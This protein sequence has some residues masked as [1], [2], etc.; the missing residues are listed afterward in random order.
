MSDHNPLILRLDLGESKKSKQF[1]FETTWVKHH[2]YLPKIKEIW[3]K[4]VTISNA[5]E[6]WCIKVNRVK[7]FLKG[8]GNNIKGRIRRYKSILKDELN[9]LEKEEEEGSLPTPLLERKTFIQTEMLKV[10]EEEEMYWHKR[11]NQKWLLQEIATQI[12]FT[13][14]PMGEKEKYDF[15]SGR[16]IIY[17]TKR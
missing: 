15:S 8:W 12:F 3:E 6:K 14:L 9:I 1:C 16:W 17:F 7:R 5:V 11:S 10:L 2:N 4:R 13:G